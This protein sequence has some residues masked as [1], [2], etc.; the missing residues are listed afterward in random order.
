MSR[1]KLLAAIVALGAGFAAAQEPMRLAEPQYLYILGCGGCHGIDG[2]SNPQLVPVLRDQVGYFMRSEEGRNYLLRLPNIA[3]STLNDRELAETLNFAV[4]ELGGASVPAGA[5][6]FTAAEV[7]R[8]RQSP[9]NEVA[10]KQYRSR[11]VSDL[12]QIHQ[13][14]PELMRYG[15]KTN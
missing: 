1:T 4:F 5:K 15:A 12:I 3:Q 7:G 9:L 14:S 11:I 10:L 13:A 6:R 2:V 8:L